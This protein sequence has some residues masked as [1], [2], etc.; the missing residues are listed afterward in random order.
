MQ[1]AQ[2]DSENALRESD[3]EFSQYEPWNEVLVLERMHTTFCE[4][5]VGLRGLVILAKL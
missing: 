1:R 3:L 5:R 2:L 4:L